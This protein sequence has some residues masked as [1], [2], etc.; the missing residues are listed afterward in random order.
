MLKW[1]ALPSWLDLS[2][3]GMEPTP[4]TSPV[5][6]GGFFT[7]ESPGEPPN[8]NNNDHKNNKG[9]DLLG[10]KHRNKHYQCIIFYNLQSM[11]E[12]QCYFY[13]HKRKPRLRV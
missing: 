6:A 1:V 5:S 12:E 2:N 11:R 13:L 7:A 10:A 8:N 9:H 3:P 4:P